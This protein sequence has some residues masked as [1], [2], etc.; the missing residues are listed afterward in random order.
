M[1]NS[2][3]AQLPLSSIISCSLL[4]FMCIES[5]MLTNHLNLSHLL[6]LQSLPASISFCLQSLLASVS[7]SMS[8]HF[9]SGGQSIGASATVPPMNI[10]DWFITGLTG[11][12]S[13][14]SEGLLRVSSSTTIWNHHSL[15]LSF[16]YDPNLTSIHDHWK[17][18]S[19][20]YMDLCWQ[21]NVSSF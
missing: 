21:S 18:H 6:C 20:N 10:Q 4:K 15:V 17:N 19:F 2:L 14:L 16:L 7:F 3:Q 9:T 8:W 5:V 1:S 11:L 13:F 12:I